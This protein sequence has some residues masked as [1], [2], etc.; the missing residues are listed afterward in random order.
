M[1]SVR[2]RLVVSSYP[3]PTPYIQELLNKCE[4]LLFVV[5]TSKTFS[6]S[7]KL[8]SKEHLRHTS[9]D[10]ARPSSHLF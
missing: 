6:F 3:G 8:S 2:A 7:L 1:S 4:S 10:V 5:R 9:F